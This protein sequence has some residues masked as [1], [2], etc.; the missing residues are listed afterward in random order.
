MFIHFTVPGVLKCAVSVLLLPVQLTRSPSLVRGLQVGEDG[1]GWEEVG[2]C[3]QGREL[4]QCPTLET[5]LK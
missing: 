5:N 1:D 3:L 4:A 2:Q